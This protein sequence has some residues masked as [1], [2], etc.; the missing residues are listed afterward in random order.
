MKDSNG[1]HQGR[2]PSEHGAGRRDLL[3]PMGYQKGRPHTALKRG[4]ETVLQA[5]RKMPVLTRSSHKTSA[6]DEHH[7]RALRPTR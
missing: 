2:Q 5:R 1:A 7:R 6:A 3:G 4:V